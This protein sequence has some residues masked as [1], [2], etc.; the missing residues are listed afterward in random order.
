MSDSKPPIIFGSMDRYKRVPCRVTVTLR[1]QEDGSVR[2]VA[3]NPDDEPLVTEAMRKMA[4]MTHCP[5][6]HK[7]TTQGDPGKP[8]R[9]ENCGGEFT[10]E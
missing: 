9:C 10:E 7:Y 3:K 5:L 4:Y 6:C 8:M 1:R 2:M